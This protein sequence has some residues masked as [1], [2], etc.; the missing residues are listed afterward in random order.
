MKT[1]RSW[2]ALPIVAAIFLAPACTRFKEQVLLKKGNELYTA[3]KYEEAIKQ[4]EQLL[5]LDPT[6]WDGN[7]LTA[8]SYLALYHP[9]SEH[10]K[11]KEFAEKGLAA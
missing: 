11:D 6:S 10:P 1:S 2:L 4:Y 7:Y 3:Q 8:V 5:K 9:G